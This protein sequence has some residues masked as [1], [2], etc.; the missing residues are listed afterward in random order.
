VRWFS[1]AVAIFDNIRVYGLRFRLSLFVKVSAA[2]FHVEVVLFVNKLDVLS[3]A[4]PDAS[5]RVRLSPRQPPLTTPAVRGHAHKNTRMHIRIHAHTNTRLQG[6]NGAYMHTH[7]H[8]HTNTHNLDEE[9]DALGVILVG[10]A[11]KV[12]ARVAVVVVLLRLGHLRSARRLQAVAPACWC[13]REPGG[14]GESG[15]EGV[16]VCVE[17]VEVG[18]KGVGEHAGTPEAAPGGAHTCFV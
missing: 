6:V 15:G 4:L 3:A 1:C 7:T 11:D 18:G 5:P 12:L 8:T 17:G 16:V 13:A 9:V 14:K 10:K 2:Y